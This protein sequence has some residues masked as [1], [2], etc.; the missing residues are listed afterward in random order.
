MI[1]FLIRFLSYFLSGHFK[2]YT[3][4]I[5]SISGR[6]SFAD[7]NGFRGGQTKPC[8]GGILVASHRSTTFPF[9]APRRSLSLSKGTSC[10][11]EMLLKIFL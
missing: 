6:Y 9:T 1:W 5:K 4:K 2:V 8:K 7:D 10:C 3:I 11:G